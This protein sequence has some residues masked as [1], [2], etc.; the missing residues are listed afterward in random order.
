LLVCLCALSAGIFPCLCLRT[1]CVNSCAGSI[2]CSHHL[3]E[4][5]RTCIEDTDAQ[6]PR[7]ITLKHPS[8]VFGLVASILR[9][10]GSSSKKSRSGYL[11]FRHLKLAYSFLPFPPFAPT[12]IRETPIQLRNGPNIYHCCCNSWHS[13]DWFRGYGKL[14]DSYEFLE[15]C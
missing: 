2:I 15:A 10:P 12:W 13:C 3:H 6:P 8:V 5:C 9:N 1:F 14:L 7:G 11:L 4:Q